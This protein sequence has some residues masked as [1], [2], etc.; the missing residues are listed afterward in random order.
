VYP[1]LPSG[2]VLI[3]DISN[4]LFM[5]KPNTAAFG[6]DGGGTTTP[7]SNGGGSTNT[8]GGGGGGAL[9]LSLLGMLLALVLAGWRGGAGALT[10]RQPVDRIRAYRR[11]LQSG[12]R[13]GRSC[14][15]LS[16]PVTAS[17]PRSHALR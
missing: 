12:C 2:T 7:P 6:T 17:G 13:L 8:G 11:G 15:S 14:E 5:L 10:S 9:D 16:Y 4:G 1:F 3:S